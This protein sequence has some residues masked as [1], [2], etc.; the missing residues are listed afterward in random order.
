MEA[1]EFDR[2]ADQYEE[3][4]R[5]N[6]AITGEGP[7]YFADTRSRR[8][9]ELLEGSELRLATSW[10]L[11]PALATPSRTSANT[12]RRRTSPARMCHDAVW[13]L[14]RPGSAPQR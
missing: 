14:P 12:C 1:A 6:I 11:A 7:E 3:Q 13:R 5:A 8:F 2:I 9:P 10:T 4:H